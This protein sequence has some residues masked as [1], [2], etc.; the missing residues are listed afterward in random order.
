MKCVCQQCGASFERSTSH[1]N[2]ANAIGARLY[3]GRTC[4]GIA[5]RTP[6]PTDA[7]VKAAKREYDKQ[8]RAANLEKIKA[9]KLAWYR[10]NHAE[11]LARMTAKRKDRMPYHLEYCRQPAYRAR[12]SEYDLQRR[13]IKQFGEFSE[14]FLILQ[15][16]E[17]EI[18]Q[19]A[20]RYEIYSQN[21]TLN[22]AQMRRRQL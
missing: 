11:I 15:E 4:A 12:K 8:Y 18:N 7:E 1:I 3:C 22:K 5:R 9:E 2:R 6:K 14:A 16:V 13:A 19:R 17:K 20:S 21:G 10:A